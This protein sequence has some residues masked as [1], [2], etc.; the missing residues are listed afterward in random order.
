MT[1]P[2]TDTAPPEPAG[3][4]PISTADQDAFRALI[5]DAVPAVQKMAAAWRTGL[6]GLITVLTTGIVLTGRTTT[7]DLTTGWRAAVTATIGGGLALAIVGLWHALA[8]E[9]GSKTRLQSLDQIRT[10]YASVQAYQVGLAATAANRLQDAR[11]L[12]ATALALLLTG[13]LLTW[14]APAAPANPPAY[15]KVTHGGT[16]TCGTLISADHGKIRLTV[17]G[18]HD[19]LAI[20]MNSVTSMT[21]TAACP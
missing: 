12:V 19:P 18:A 21:M 2:E 9:A 5:D 8:A 20:P 15:L 6:V 1:N 11:R 3:P 13:V 16:S 14:W 17:T 10:Q 4:R 7:T